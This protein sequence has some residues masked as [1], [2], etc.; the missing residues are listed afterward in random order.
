MVFHRGKK[1]LLVEKKELQPQ[2]FI[3]GQSL[4][5][6]EV[7]SAGKIEIITVVFQPYAARAILQLPLK[8]FYGELIAVDATEDLELSIVQK[9]DRG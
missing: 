5:F 9:S 8:L 1:L 2:A 6:L 4:N 3:C 7:M